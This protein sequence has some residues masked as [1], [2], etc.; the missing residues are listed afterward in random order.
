MA[1][2]VVFMVIV[3]YMPSQAVSMLFVL[4]SL[5]MPSRARWKI[6]N[7]ICRLVFSRTRC[8]FTRDQVFYR[9]SE[10]PVD[11]QLGQPLA[12]PL[13]RDGSLH[14]QYQHLRASLSPT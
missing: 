14:D 7:L 2:A 11:P 1:T 12:D 10:A 5:V 4:P 3:L 9:G 8:K 13:G 6:H